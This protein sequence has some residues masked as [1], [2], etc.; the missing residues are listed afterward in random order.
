MKQSGYQY[1]CDPHDPEMTPH[2]S[3]NAILSISFLSEMWLDNAR[4][5]VTVQEIT[6]PFGTRD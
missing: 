1:V 5:Y 4:Y 3:I 6:D 2:L